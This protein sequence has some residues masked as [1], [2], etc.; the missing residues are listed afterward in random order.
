MRENVLVE[1][2]HHLVV[3]LFG[4]VAGEFEDV[5]SLG[6]ILVDGAELTP[7]VSEQD[8][9]MLR[10][11]LTHLLKTNVMKLVCTFYVICRNSK[12]MSLFNF[13]C[14]RTFSFLF[15]FAPFLILSPSSVSLPFLTLWT[16]SV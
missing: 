15:L 3:Q 11:R 1:P 16:S 5:L 4:S 10:L 13:F 12:D 7:C 9:V 8:D 2:V 6:V 14:S